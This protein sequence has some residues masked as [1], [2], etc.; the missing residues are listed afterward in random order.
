[1]AAAV[2]YWVA[3]AIAAGSAYQ[4]GQ[5]KKK[6]AQAD[7]DMKHEQANIAIKQSQEEEAKLHTQSV[8]Q[9]GAI[10]EGIGA[11]GIK[12]EGSALDVLQMSAQNA[13]ADAQA[14]RT[15]GQ[16]KAWAYN[17]SASMSE[18]Q[19]AAA[20][21]AGN[22]SAAGT[23]IGAAGGASKAGADFWSSSPSTSTAANGTM[24]RGG[25]AI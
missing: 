24:T 1:M 6:A 23:L 11:S 2:V 3:A 16:R 14:I 9:I 21:R 25:Y 7:A 8:T 5:D 18:M 13:E 10:R 22:W 15:N 12:A 17:A 20:E 19:G 4:Q